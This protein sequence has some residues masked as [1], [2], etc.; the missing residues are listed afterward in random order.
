MVK[1]GILSGKTEIEVMEEYIRRGFAE[2]FDWISTG[3]VELADGE[4]RDLR[5]EYHELIKKAA[6]G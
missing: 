3:Q 4:H 2:L 5:A 1:A 6:N